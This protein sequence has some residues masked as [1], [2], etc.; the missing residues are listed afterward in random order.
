[1]LVSATQTCVSIQDKAGKG[2]RTREKSRGRGVPEREKRD[3][4]EAAFAPGHDA[5]SEA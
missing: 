1:M 5:P 4:G 2:E 3:Q